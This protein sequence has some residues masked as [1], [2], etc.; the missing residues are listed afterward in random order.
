VRTD[1]L[2]LASWDCPGALCSKD[3]VADPDGAGR[4]FAGM[5]AA[6][7]PDAGGGVRSSCPGCVDFSM[8][9]ADVHF[10][11]LGEQDGALPVM[12]GSPAGRTLL[13]SLGL[14]P[15]AGTAR[16][17]LRAEMERERRETSRR[18]ADEAAG[19][20]LRGAE[21]LLSFFSA[22]IGCR[23]CRAVCP[24]CHC[25]LCHFDSETPRPDPDAF[26][27]GAELRGGASLPANRLLFH[28]GRMTHMSLSCVSC[29]QCSDACPAGIP[30][31][32]AFGFVGRAAREAFGYEAGRGD[33]IPHPLRTWRRIE[34]D[35]IGGLVRDA[36]P[37]ACA[38]E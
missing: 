12:A 33:G 4:R 27:D 35:G 28:V 3:H 5:I 36:E 10:G 6:G 37:G 38:H 8:T 29:G 26:F 7:S 2:L 1:G 20:K 23:I 21:G 9:D 13:G 32:D 18:A 25:R 11:L 24:I 14:T 19:S 16:W 15:A 22:C 34:P 31:A 17:K 30:V